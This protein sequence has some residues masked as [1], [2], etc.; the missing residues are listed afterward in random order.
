[1]RDVAHWDPSPGPLLSCLFWCGQDY[2]SE[3]L[4]LAQAYRVWRVND[5]DPCQRAR[6]R[7][8]GRAEGV[9]AQDISGVGALGV[10]WTPLGVIT[11]TR[12]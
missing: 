11:V 9:G 2:T 10:P 6:R 1:M 5:L 4:P 12:D 3:S 8:K 7:P